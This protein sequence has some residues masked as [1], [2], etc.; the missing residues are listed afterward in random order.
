MGGRNEGK[1]AWEIT[2]LPWS[3]LPHYLTV[4]LLCT[5][6]SASL[7]VVAFLAVV[8]TAVSQSMR[9]NSED[10]NTW[11]AMVRV[12]PSCENTYNNV[13]APF[14]AND[15]ACK[16]QVEKALKTYNKAECPVT[17]PTSFVWTCMSGWNGSRA[18]SVSSA[19]NRLPGV[20][21]RVPLHD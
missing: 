18:D 11:N 7:A 12:K 6:A 13:V 14:F 15:P 1:K 10:Q 9:Q 19:A 16:E 17:T 21:R 5:M 2:C 4:W 20:G 3:T 8:A